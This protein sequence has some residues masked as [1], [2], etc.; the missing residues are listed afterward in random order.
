MFEN[1]LL[2]YWSDGLRIYLNEY[3]RCTYRFSSRHEDPVYCDVR[4]RN[5]HKMHIC[6]AAPGTNGSSKVL[7]AQGDFAQLRSWSDADQEV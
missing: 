5:R 3:E 1:D 6:S 4:G 2:K 7:E